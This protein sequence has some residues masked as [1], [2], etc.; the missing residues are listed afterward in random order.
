[1]I[2]F[3]A[4]QSFSL[5]PHEDRCP[6]QPCVGRQLFDHEPRD[7][8]AGYLAAFDAGKIGDRPGAPASWV[9][10]EHGGTY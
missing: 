9:I 3:A 6:P 7:I 4:I 2:A 8:G 1:M 10:G 5:S